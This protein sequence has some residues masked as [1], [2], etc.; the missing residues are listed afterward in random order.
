MVNN[1]KKKQSSRKLI[2]LDFKINIKPGPKRANSMAV[3]GPVKKFQH[4]ENG[5]EN[6]GGST[7]KAMKRV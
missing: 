6:T 7:G 4:S 5:A 3:K 2:E 1:Y